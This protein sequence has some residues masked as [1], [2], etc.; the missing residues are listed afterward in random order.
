M[1]IRMRIHR[2]GGARGRCS[3]LDVISTRVL[4]LLVSPFLFSSLV[5]QT[6][7]PRTEK[8]RGSP[9]HDGRK[10]KP[11]HQPF[12]LFRPSP[13]L[14]T[15]SSAHCIRRLSCGEGS[16]ARRRR[17]GV[18]VWVCVAVASVV[19]VGLLLRERGWWCWWGIWG[20][21]NGRVDYMCGR[22][23]VYCWIP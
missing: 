4:A 9:Q 23:T 15:T 20:D 7:I 11:K 8:K 16:V 18:D 21:S 6:Y 22:V 2:L 1:R 3:R 19:V 10:L 12:D 14:S 5:I 13:S 17:T